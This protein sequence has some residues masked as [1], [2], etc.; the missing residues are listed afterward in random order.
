MVDSGCTI[1]M[2]LSG[3]A[4]IRVVESAVELEICERGWWKED[5]RRVQVA[6]FGVKHLGAGSCGSGGVHQP[7]RGVDGANGELRSPRT[8]WWGLTF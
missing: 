7:P 1:E 2:A 3:E 4:K 5:A 8:L 6:T